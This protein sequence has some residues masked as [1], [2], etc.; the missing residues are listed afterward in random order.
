MMDRLARIEMFIRVVEEG[1]F[2]AAARSLKTTQPTVSKAVAELEQQLKTRLVH[3]TTRTLSP[4]EAGAAYYKR[5][6][7]LVDLLYEADND[8]APGQD[9]V[10][11][12]LRVNTSAL[13][14]GKLVMPAIAAFK[15]A[16]PSVA[17]EVEMDDRRIDLV[18]HATD[19]AVRVGSLSDSTLRVRRAGTASSGLF[20]SPAYLAR[21]GLKLAEASD[22][23]RVH[24]VRYA[25]Q[26]TLARGK[27]EGQ[28]SLTVSNG[29][30]ARE[31]CL[32]G[33]GVA[34]VP[35]F[36][37]AD[38]VASGLLLR[39]EPDSPL[40]HFEVSLLHPFPHDAPRSV[41]SFIEF[42]IAM[43]R[44]RGFLQA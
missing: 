10:R 20:V 3:R 40:P 19:V 44:E 30:L 26:N 4:T 15:L 21:T 31:A 23:A 8:A 2:S 27:S 25:A 12:R 18:E 33:V 29:L 7:R 22:L 34:A 24:F 36:L 32:A 41:T 43:W 14:A 38:D 16:H 5:V 13:L 37:V 28:V 11:G 9:V 35:D 1:S 6:K 42:A 17:I 39:I